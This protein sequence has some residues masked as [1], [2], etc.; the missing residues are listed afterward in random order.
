MK[1]KKQPDTLS[2]VQW[3]EDN[4]ENHGTEHC[5]E[6][7]R[8]GAVQSGEGGLR[9]DVLNATADGFTAD[10]AKLLSGVNSK[11]AGRNGHRLK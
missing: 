11:R 4:R 9:R 3:R 10:R 2:P 6:A 7:G 5:G 1:G 8:A